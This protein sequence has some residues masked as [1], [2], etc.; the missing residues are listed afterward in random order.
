MTDIEADETPSDSS[1]T[2]RNFLLRSGQV[3]WMF[4]VLGSPFSR[5]VA[6]ARRQFADM[7][8]VA[9][10]PALMLPAD[11][12]SAFQ[13]RML[14]PF[15]GG[16][17]AA[18]TGV[19]GR[20]NEFYFGAVNGGVWKSID[21]GRVWDPVFDSQPVASIGA[22]AV[23]PSAPDIVY[24]GSGEST[25]RD[26]TGFGNGMYK[27]IDAGK[28]WTH[29]GL[30]RHAAHREDR[31]RSAQ[32]RRRVRRRDRAA[33]RANTERGVFRSHDGGTSWQKVLYKDADVGAVEVVIDPTNS[34]VVYAGLW[35]TRRP[36]WFTY[37]PTNGP[38]GGIYKSVD[39]GARWK[40]LTAGCPGKGS[41]ARES[42]CRRAIRGGCTRWWTACSP[43]TAPARRSERR[44]AA[45]GR[46]RCRKQG[47][48][49]RSDDAGATWT[50][51]SNDPALWGRGWY[52]GKL[53]VDPKDAEIVYVRTCRCRARGRREE[54]GDAARI[55][56]W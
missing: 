43:R 22:I 45:H 20:P 2:R 51:L 42:R 46:S 56:G 32:P 28:S 38:G 1:L 44:R 39:G 31:D 12:L 37:S 34:S 53:A 29:I 41:A 11:L 16:R 24:V 4:S 27:S 54:L 8:S 9:H 17:V 48:F 49:F 35:N 25:L 36:P 7:M 55:A 30:D 21:A 40:Q 13:W 18:A 50:R 23:A 47:G 33:V 52:F 15:R 6:P 3:G 10:C 5:F 26:S 19:P 14:G